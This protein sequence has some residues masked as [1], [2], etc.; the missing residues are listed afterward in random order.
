MEMTRTTTETRPRVA[1]AGGVGDVGLLVLRGVTGVVMAYHGWLKIDGGIENFQGFVDSLGLPLPELL[2]P[3]VTYLEL[4]GGILLI[5]GLVTRVPAL[6]IAIEMLFTAFLV[7]ATKL[8]VGLIEQQGTGSEIDLMIFAA[9]AAIVLFGP[10]R[11]SLDRAF[12]IEP[13]GTRL[14]RG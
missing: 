11:L 13:L 10:G 1:S 14:G 2:A 8:D 6:L 12:R 7:K 5:L 9:C 4:I 3:A